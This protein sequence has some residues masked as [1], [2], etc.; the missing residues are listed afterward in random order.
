MQAHWAPWQICP[1]AHA[2]PHAPQFAGSV[3]RLTQAPLQFVVP[4]A[5]PSSQDPAEHTLPAEQTFL[6]DPQFEGSDLRST[7][8]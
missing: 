4:V 7:Q 2:A 6:H 3:F 8:S 5:H 1:A